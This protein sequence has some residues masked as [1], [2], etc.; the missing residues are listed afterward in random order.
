MWKL[1]KKRWATEGALVQL[2]GLDDRLLAD[3]GFVRD[4]L[5]DQIQA[6]AKVQGAVPVGS[7]T[8]VCNC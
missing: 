7:G 3:M 1:L 5:R 2:R 6:D 8:V 4:G